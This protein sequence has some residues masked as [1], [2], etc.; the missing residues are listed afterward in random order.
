MVPYSREVKLMNY[1]H[2]VPIKPHEITITQHC[3]LYG[4]VLTLCVLQ[5]QQEVVHHLVVDLGG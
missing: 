4:H 1:P 2:D 5:I 3:S